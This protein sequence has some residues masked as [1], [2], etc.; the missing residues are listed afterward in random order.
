MNRLQKKCFIAS[1]GFHLLLL[2]LIL[3]VGPAFFS[4]NK[5]QNTEVLTFFDLSKVT[6]GQTAGTGN[7]NPVPPPQSR[8]IVQPPRPQPPQ[9]IVKPQDPAPVPPEIK[10]NEKN[11]FAEK[12]DKSKHKI[13][14]STT[15]VARSQTKP[16]PNSTRNDADAKA[17]EQAT[18]I[19]G[20]LRNAANSLKSN[21]SKGTAFELPGNGGEGAVN[22]AQAV[23]SIYYDAWIPPDELP[24][25]E[26]LSA[27][28]SVTISTDGDVLS[29]E[30]VKRSGNSVLD[31]SVQHAL[32]RVKSTVPF[33]S[34]SKDKVR[35]IKI[36]FNPIVKR[37]A[38]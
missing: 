13:E 26:G 4:G 7:P 9:Q 34:G 15:P 23:V 32:N 18:K 31:T 25:D 28:V 35:T 12:Q 27:K 24:S 19:A 21:L 16:N 29:T 1:A 14:V 38:G 5:P 22:W 3:F 11:P 36:N 37:Q 17:R 8:E 10:S 20:A 30:I 33:P 2:L 6:D